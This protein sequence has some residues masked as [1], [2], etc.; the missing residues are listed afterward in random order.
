MLY[1]CAA[2]F[3]VTKNLEN[4]LDFGV[5]G[6]IDCQFGTLSLRLTLAHSQVKTTLAAALLAAAQ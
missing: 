3:D 5:K 4:F 2:R 6:H 1:V